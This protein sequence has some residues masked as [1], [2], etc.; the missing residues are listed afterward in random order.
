MFEWLRQALRHLAARLGRLLFL[1]INDLLNDLRRDVPQLL[2]LLGCLLL[3]VGVE[4]LV[5]DLPI[6]CCR[7]LLGFLLK[8]L[9]IPLISC[10]H[11]EDVLLCIIL[12]FLWQ[13]L[14]ASCAVLGR[15]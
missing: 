7:E 8:E 15:G 11:I 3:H 14:S 4:V 10:R 9:G 1:E 13:R 2:L 12:E 5:E 6:M